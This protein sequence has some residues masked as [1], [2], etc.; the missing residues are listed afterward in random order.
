MSNFRPVDRATP[1][2]LP[3]SV[4]EWLPTGHLARFVAEIVQQLDLRAL[5]SAYR[6]SGKAAYHPEM[7]VGLL[8]YG[9]ATGTYSSRA[10]EK[11]TYDSVAFRYIAA[12]QHP[13]HDTLCAF[14]RRFLK[15]IEQLFMQVLQVAGEMKLVKLGTVSL[16]GTKIHANASRHNALSYGR[17]QKIEGQ[18]RNEVRNLLAR[19]EAADSAPLPAGLSIPDE[20]ARR[21]AR[22]AAIAE[23]KAK[24]E[25]RAA[26]RLAAE[27]QRYEERLAAREAKAK[28]RGKRP[29]GKPPQP[30]TGGARETDQINLTDEESR[31][32][33]RSGGGGFDQ[34][35][36][37]QA[38]V[39]AESML[40][41]GAHVS[42]SPS[43]VRQVEP[44]LEHLSKVPEEL[45]RAETLLADAGFFSQ[46]NVERC[47]D[48]AIR[49]LIARR[50][51]QH[52]AP[53]LDRLAEPS[54]LDA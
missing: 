49:P 8:I 47:R 11:A 42:A 13:D 41:V 10:I 51:D 53:W 24:I 38:A 43:D 45:G 29:G 34:C 52:Y 48:R 54:P 17:A 33:P 16:D 50:R 46:A 15:E 32:M 31:I 21:E 19:A 40:I 20:L 2:L 35:Y 12:N 22:L 28:A 44:M 4:D 9:Y 36:N 39:D 6:G 25:A 3:P 5:E 23:A 14:R 1:Y 27:Q 37:A 7:L 26:E 18:L 30:P